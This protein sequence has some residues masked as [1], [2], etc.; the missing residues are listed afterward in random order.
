MRII[1]PTAIALIRGAAGDSKII[2]SLAF[3]VG[4]AELPVCTISIFDAGFY[5][6]TVITIVA[7]QTMAVG[8][9]GSAAG[10]AVANIAATAFGIGLTSTG[11]TG[12]FGEFTVG[13]SI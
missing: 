13:T 12:S 9:A 3:L 4:I 2:F 7:A 5:T 8:R 11:F 10:I 1:T 6:C